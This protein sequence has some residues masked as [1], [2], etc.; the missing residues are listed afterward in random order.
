MPIEVGRAW[1]LMCTSKRYAW[2]NFKASKVCADTSSLLCWIWRI[3]AETK[4]DSLNYPI[5]DFVIPEEYK[6]KIL[7]SERYTQT[8]KAY[9]VLNKEIIRIEKYLNVT[10]DESLLEPKSSP[11]VE[12]NKIIEPVVP[13]P[14][15]SPSLEVNALESGYPKSIKEARSHPIEQVI[16]WRALDDGDDVVVKLSLDSS[17]TGRRMMTFEEED[18]Y[19]WG[20]LKSSDVDILQYITKEN[21]HALRMEMREIHASINND[22]KVFTAVIEDIAKVFLKDQDKE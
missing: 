22:L 16:G 21:M 20:Q 14:I 9:M 13:N 3:V 12:D 5:E 18:Y 15:R 11:S 4:S 19:P 1:K 8:S 10:F 6:V 17:S 7:Q 2:P